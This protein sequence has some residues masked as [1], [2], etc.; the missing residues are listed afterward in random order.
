MNALGLVL[1]CAFIYYLSDQA[2]LPIPELFSWQDKLEHF[3]AYAVMGCLAWRCFQHYVRSM[4]LLASISFLFCTLHGGLDEYHQSF[5]IGRVADITDWLADSLGG[6]L[7]VFL[8]H[9][10]VS[11]KA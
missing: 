11:R 5:V 10:R 1:Y 6:A 2:T 4:I 7:A 3:G 9:R 8:L